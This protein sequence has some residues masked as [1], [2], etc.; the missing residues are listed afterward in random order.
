VCENVI[1]LLPSYERPE[2]EEINGKDREKMEDPCLPPCVWPGRACSA[3]GTTLPSRRGATSAAAATAWSGQGQGQG[4]GQGGRGSHVCAPA[5]RTLACL[6][7]G[8][9][10]HTTPH[11]TARPHV[12]VG[13][14]TARLLVSADTTSNCKLLAKQINHIIK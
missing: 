10:L 1:I 2:T 5:R 6:F 13:C 7:S 8:P 12:A 4:Q 14:S 9:L 3:L 11:H